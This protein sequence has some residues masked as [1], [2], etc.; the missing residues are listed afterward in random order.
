MK[1]MTFNNS[2]FFT[3][4]SNLLLDFGIDVSDKDII[5]ESRIP[6]VF[7]VDK[8][9]GSYSAGYQVQDVAI[10]N[11]YLAR[12]G[13]LFKEHIFLKSDSLINK[14]DLIESLED[15]KNLIVSLKVLD[16]I[17]KS[18]A[19]IF[20]S[21]VDGVYTFQNMKRRD[22]IEPDYYKFNYKELLDKLSDNVQYGW[23][24]IHDI[25]TLKVD[26]SQVKKESIEVLNKYKKEIIEYCSEVKTFK[27]R[28]ESK[29]KLFRA[30]MISYLSVSKIVGL[31]KLTKNI[32]ELRS[33]YLM[34]FQLKK[35]I[36]LFDYVSSIMIQDT[37]SMIKDFISS[38]KI[39]MIMHATSWCDKTN[40]AKIKIQRL[41]DSDS[42]DVI[43]EFIPD[44]QDIFN[45]RYLTHNGIIVRHDEISPLPYLENH[46][47]TLLESIELSDNDVIHVAGGVYNDLGGCLNYLHRYMCNYVN[48]TGVKLDIEILDDATY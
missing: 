2:C 27:Q 38:K 42:Y 16:N 28:A 37:L 10:I 11:Q 47:S 3:V 15:K 20:K 22:S 26:I 40:K 25:S 24:E 45:K 17:N 32:E 31:K 13:V 34:T 4:L 29:D 46:L 21:Y 48:K 19:T 5:A 6:F 41:I 35:S 30:L 18:H 8:I 39:L 9:S 7:N 43:I 23:L 1:Y 44:R 33:Q 36:R 14:R 12:Y